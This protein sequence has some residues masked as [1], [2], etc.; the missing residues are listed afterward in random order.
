[1]RDDGGTLSFFDFEYAGCDDPAKLAADFFCQP[2]LPVDRRYWEEFV[3]LLARGLSLDSAFVERAR[4]LRQV[5][6]LKWCGIMLN[7]F[8]R[9][10]AERRRFAGGGSEE[11]KQA[12]LAKARKALHA[13][14]EERS[15]QP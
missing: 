3:T 15:C 10:D 12:Q 7:E 2:E 6:Q 1:L 4:L 8:L 9:R 5:Y 13:A 14:M 11:R